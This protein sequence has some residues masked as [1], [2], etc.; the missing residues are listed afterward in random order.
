MEREGL[1]IA[2]WSREMQNGRRL[3]L[4]RAPWSVGEIF[5][6]S[7]GQYEFWFVYFSKSCRRAYTEKENES[8]RQRRTVLY[9]TNECKRA[10]KKK[11]KY[12]QMYKRNRSWKLKR[13]RRNIAT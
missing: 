6:S 1:E 13:K 7:D 8:Q 12:A 3:E 10:I 11:K 9:M 4:K 5:D 2:I